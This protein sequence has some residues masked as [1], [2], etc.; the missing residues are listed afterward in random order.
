[1]SVQTRSKRLLESEVSWL[2]TAA[3]TGVVLSS[4]GRFFSTIF[5]LRC[6][7]RV[8]ALQG[9]ILLANV[10]TSESV[11]TIRTERIDPLDDLK[12]YKGGFNITN[13]HYWGSVIFTGKFGYIIGAAWLVGGLIYAVISIV[14]SLCFNRNGRYERKRLNSFNKGHNWPLLIAILLTF[15][16]IISSG[17]AL[18]ASSKFHSQAKTIKNIVV[19]ATNTASGTI[20]TVTEAIENLQNDTQLSQNV[21]GSSKIAS[22]SK[23]LNDDTRRLERKAKRIMH[24][25]S[26]GLNILNAVTIIT[27]SLNLVAILAFFGA[28]RLPRIVRMVIIICW[29]L[30]ILLWA[31]FGLYYFLGKFAGDICI[32]LDEYKQ[33]PER[34]TL[35][36]ILPCNDRGSAAT[37]LYDVSSRVYE[38]IQE[39][40]S[41]ITSLKPSISKLE[42]ICNPFSG[43]PGYNYQPENCSSNTITVGQVPQLIEN[44]ACSS[45]D[46]GG[47]KPGEFI[48]AHIY[49]KLENYTKSMQDI[50]DSYP[51]MKSLI[52]CQLVKDAF[53]NILFNHCKPLKKYVHISWASLAALS[54]V[55]VILILIWELNAHQNHKFCSLDGS[56]R[57]SSTPTE[58][59]E[60][61]PA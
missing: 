46:S 13:K 58:S 53:S 4:F 32:A 55:M 54:T 18:G 20:Y 36:S 12:R 16:A 29:L 9:W 7:E 14:L 22:S 42:Y 3:M 51:V 57:P 56:V 24:W 40:N 49:V 50:L 38:L 52:N 59:T 26:K 21:A 10:N 8:S 34:S 23:K 17:V 47:C 15:L 39:V 2:T 60:V 45:D 5:F 44:F 37:V 6:S 41:N 48:P 30:I 35:S 43:P 25:V 11:L 1:M 28:L 27:V 31:Y 19:N 33:N 61:D